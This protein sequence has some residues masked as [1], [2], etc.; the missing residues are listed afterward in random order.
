M[1]KAV[2]AVVGA[3]T[4]SAV[5]TGCMAPK[6]D[7]LAAQR[8]AV[9]TMRDETLATLYADKPIVKE[10]IGKAAGYGV[11]SNLDINL[12]VISAGNGYGVVR[13]NADLKDTYMKMG[14]IGVGFGAG[15]K[16]FKAV[17]I[18]KS[19]ESMD[20]FVDNG[21]EWGASA[22]AAAKAGDAGGQAGTSADVT[23]D[24]EIYTITENGI[25]LQAM[26][27][28]TKYWKNDDLN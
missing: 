11:F 15:V 10:K 8:K 20:S 24:I 16:D 14:T 5:M 17:M 4:V 25:V 2:I 19:A 1:R 6:G 3:V 21:F 22:D 7:S 23:G 13:S 12:L 18:F 28:G 26:I 9:L 27:A